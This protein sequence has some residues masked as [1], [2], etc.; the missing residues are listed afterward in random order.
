MPE[1][2]ASVERVARSVRRPLRAHLL[3]EVRTHLS[4]QTVCPDCGGELRKSGQDESEVLERIPAPIP[5]DPARSRE[6]DLQV[7][8]T[9]R[10]CTSTESTDRTQHGR[11]ELLDHVLASKFSDHL[12]LY[13]QSEIYAREGVELDRSKS[14]E[15]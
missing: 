9:H 12:P 4:K 15:Q 14:T 8:R 3:R 6:A 10:A 7:P 1:A 13:R 11:T 5:S 2:M